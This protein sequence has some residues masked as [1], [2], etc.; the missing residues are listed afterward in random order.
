MPIHHVKDYVEHLKSKPVHVRQRVAVATSGAITGL[1]ALAWVVSLSASGSL[2][3]SPGPSVSAN[4]ASATRDSGEEFSNLLG[5]A[6]AFRSGLEGGST[7]TVVDT[8]ASSTLDRPGEKDERT[9]I[10]F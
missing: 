6:G 4:I 7:I 5:A 10:P 2:A 9:V 8:K 3:L 1:I